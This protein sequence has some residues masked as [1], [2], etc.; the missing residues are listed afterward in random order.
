MS[1]D[2]AQRLELQKFHLRSESE[3]S[4]YGQKQ[5]GVTFPRDL[6]ELLSLE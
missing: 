6:R 1:A 4:D 2:S 3:T 5:K